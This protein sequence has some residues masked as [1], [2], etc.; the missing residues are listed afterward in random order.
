MAEVNEKWTRLANKLK[1]AVAELEKAQKEHDD[2]MSAAQAKLTA[3]I[4]HAQQLVNEVA[5]TPPGTF[6][7]IT[8]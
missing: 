7:A 8:G 5:E 3:A 6:P 4:D 1:S 2:A